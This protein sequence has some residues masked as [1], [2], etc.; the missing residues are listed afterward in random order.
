MFRRLSPLVILVALLFAAEPLLHSHPLESTIAG[1]SGT[2]ICAVCATG[3]G[4][5]PTMAPAIAAPQLGAYRY[6]T[7]FFRA[8]AVETP[9]PLPSRAPPAA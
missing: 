1:A 4:R 3:T 6:V 9:L 8:V 5:L 7:V 2:S